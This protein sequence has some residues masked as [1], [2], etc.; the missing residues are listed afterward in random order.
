MKMSSFLASLSLFYLGYL[1]TLSACQSSATKGN[2][3]AGFNDAVPSYFSSKFPKAQGIYWD[4]LE[5]NTLSF[6]FSNGAD[7][8]EALFDSKGNYLS[9]T[10]FIDLQGLPQPAQ[11][12]IASHYPASERPLIQLYDSASVKTYLLELANGVDYIDLSFDE[13]GKMLKET[14]QPLSKEEIQDAEEEGVNNE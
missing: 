4:T 9:T 12:Y 3:P 6:K 14:T 5:N 11:D 1:F 13:Q 2:A 8:C 10:F 7:D